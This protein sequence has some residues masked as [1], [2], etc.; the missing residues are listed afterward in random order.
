[1]TI[2]ELIS[3]LKNFGKGNEEVFIVISGVDPEVPVE[4]GDVLVIEEAGGWETNLHARVIRVK[5]R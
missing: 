4:D 3:D 5:P 1:M 2:D